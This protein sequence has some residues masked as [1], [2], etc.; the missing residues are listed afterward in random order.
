M[1]DAALRPLHVPPRGPKRPSLGNAVVQTIMSGHDLRAT[2]I[3]G[4]CAP[5]D[6]PHLVAR[7]GIT[8]WLIPSIWP[9]TFSFTTHECLATGRPTMAFDLGAQ[10]DAVRA[11]ENGI[12]M[13]WPAASEKRQPEELACLMLAALRAPL[14]DRA[15]CDGVA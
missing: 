15:G 10:G 1:I 9:E 11:A 4:V 3:H 13:P 6:I 7:Y 2:P 5:E 14:S 8:H 12:L